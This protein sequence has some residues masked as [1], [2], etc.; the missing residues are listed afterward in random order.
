MFETSI[1]DVRVNSLWE[2]YILWDYFGLN[3]TDLKVMSN[4]EKRAKLW[5]CSC[6]E[7]KKKQK[8]IEME[9]KSRW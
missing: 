3:K 6:M 9:M 5:F 8:Q 1:K 4:R 2:E 7:R